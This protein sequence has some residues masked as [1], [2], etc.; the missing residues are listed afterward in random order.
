MKHALWLVLVLCLPGV[1]VKAQ[2]AVIGMD[3][4][5]LRVIEEVQLMID[6]EDFDAAEKRLNNVLGR[7]LSGYERAQVLRLLGYVHWQTEAWGKAQAVYEEALGQRRLPDSLRGNLMATLARLALLNEEWA[8]AEKHLVS[9]LGIASQNTPEH[10][11]L[12]AQAYVGAERWQDAL[13]AAQAAIESRSEQGLKPMESWLSLLASI[14]YSLE[15]FV[16]MRE[17][18][19]EIAL[20]WP[21][22]QHLMNL[23]ALHGQLGETERQLALVEAMFDHG[24]VVKESNL[25]LLSGLFLAEGLPHKAATLLERSIEEG[26]VKPT[27][28][29]LERLSQAWYLSAEPSKAI[30]PLE[31]AAELSED[32]EL[33]MRVA[34]LQLDRY[35]WSEAEV[36]ASKA[37]EKGG[38]PDPAAAWLLRGMA[39]ARMEQFAEAQA[40]FEK[41]LT[42]G[43]QGAQAEQWLSYIAR[44]AE[45]KNLSAKVA[46]GD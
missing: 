1:A 9:L 30:P 42:Y 31:R 34:R 11:M 14:H 10:Q 24:R 44:E 33:Y 20:L 15:D 28:R 38:L 5:I 27:R 25:L 41:A 35:R 6:E 4:R 8:A 22:E 32:G 7:S 46:G 39:L 23:A 13:P 29:H 45:R 40:F 18:M 3:E 37:L 43:K 12:L 2:E 21:R 19:T 17:V 26:R 36:A 16:A